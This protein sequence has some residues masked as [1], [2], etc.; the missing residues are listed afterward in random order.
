MNEE[1]RR[2]WALQV[3]AA[4]QC[5]ADTAESIVVRAEQYLAFLN[6]EAATVS[7]R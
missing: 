6:G 4:H 7:K 2:Q 5:D 1:E 3:A